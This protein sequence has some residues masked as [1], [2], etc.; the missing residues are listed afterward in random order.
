MTFFATL[1]DVSSSVIDIGHE[2]IRA[3]YSGEDFGGGCAL[4]LEFKGVGT[5]TDPTKHAKKCHVL[6]VHEA[7]V[8]ITDSGVQVSS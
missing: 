6:I 1:D 5:A 3:G 8:S 2:E 7:A 4:L